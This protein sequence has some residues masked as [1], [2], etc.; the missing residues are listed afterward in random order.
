M[1]LRGTFSNTPVS[2]QVTIYTPSQRLWQLFNYF[3]NGV[4]PVVPTTP[5]TRSHAESLKSLA[6]S[7]FCPESTNAPENVAGPSTVPKSSDKAKGGD[8]PG[9]VIRATNERSGVHVASLDAAVRPLTLD[10]PFSRSFPTLPP[11][12]SRTLK[13]KGKEKAVDV[14]TAA[15]D[16]FPNSVNALSTRMSDALSPLFEAAQHDLRELQE[17]ID[18]L[19]RALMQLQGIASQGIGDVVL[20]LSQQAEQGVQGLASKVYSAASYRNARARTNAKKVRDAGERY[21]STARQ[22]LE[23]GFER[24]RGNAKEVFSEGR[25]MGRIVSRSKQLR[26]ESRR[27][28]RQAREESRRWGQ[29]AREHRKNAKKEARAKRA[30]CR[31]KKALGAECL[32]HSVVAYVA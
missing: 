10:A 4:P 19:L 23:T 30:E 9:S 8:E 13:G 11:A 6:A 22:M 20:A 24:A 27:L 31:K 29:Q 15:P 5:S 16:P 26:E 2:P 3:P 17:A 7:V 28:R 21:V 32:F 1:V 12:R 14:F 25:P 18:G